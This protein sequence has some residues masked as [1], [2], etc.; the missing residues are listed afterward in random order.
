MEDINPKINAAVEVLKQEIMAFKKSLHFSIV[1]NDKAHNASDMGAMMA[2]HS[3]F[4]Q[5]ISYWIGLLD[6]TSVPKPT[7]PSKEQQTFDK[8]TTHIKNISTYN[9]DSKILLYTMLFKYSV[10][11]PFDLGEKKELPE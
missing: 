4:L 10:Q 8:L 1:A 6:T 2:F 11:H 7:L 9:S 3:R 5:I